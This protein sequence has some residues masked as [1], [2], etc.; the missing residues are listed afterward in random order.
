MNLIDFEKDIEEF[1][2]QLMESKLYKEYKKIDD[3]I[4]NNINIINLSK[5]RDKLYEK[6][7]LDMSDDKLLIEAK[8]INDK[9]QEF[10][11]V[12]KYYIYRKKIKNILSIID[13]EIIKEVVND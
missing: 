6:Y 5:E 3:E 2:S 13:K 1:I 8:N 7:S 9:I 10:D 12:K 4:S 11:I